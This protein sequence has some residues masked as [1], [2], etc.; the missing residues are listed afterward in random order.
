MSFLGN[1]LRRL[2]AEKEL[3]E[4]GFITAV[5]LATEARTH[6][7]ERVSYGALSS[8]IFGNG[9]HSPAEVERLLDYFGVSRERAEQ[10]GAEETGWL[11]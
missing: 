7:R 9:R 4:G 5:S 11:P 3:K 8:I 1:G 10:I 6:T 2:W